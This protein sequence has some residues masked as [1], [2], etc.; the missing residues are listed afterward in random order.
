M[1]TQPP[2][3]AL[4]VFFSGSACSRAP[5]RRKTS[6]AS[7]ASAVADQQAAR[8]DRDLVA[9]A[10]QVLPV[11]G[12]Q[13]VEAI[14]QRGHRAAPMRSSA[15]AS[16]PRICGPLVRTIRPY[17]P[18]R[19]AASSSSVPAVI[20]PAPP[21]PAMATEKLRDIGLPGGDV[22]DMELLLFEA[23]SEPAGQ[24]RLDLIQIKCALQKRPRIAANR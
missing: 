22:G 14:I 13:H 9:E 15:A 23:A 19:A 18:A 3:A 10:V 6:G 7:P 21:L 1:L 8:A 20:T 12:Q 16:P 5:W 24:P 4:A 2:P 17:R 11:D